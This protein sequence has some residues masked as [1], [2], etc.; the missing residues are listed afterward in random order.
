MASPQLESG[1]ARISH[2]LLQ[3]I[4][5]ARLK[6]APRAILDC[7]IAHTYGW[8]RKEAA[9]S[10]DAFVAWTGYSQ[11]TCRD[12]INSLARCRMITW[13]NHQKPRIFGV[14]KDYEKWK[15]PEH[16]ANK[17]AGTSGKLGC[18]VLQRKKKEEISREGEKRETWLT[19][20]DKLW[21][22][23]FGAHLPFGQAANYLD[24]LVKEH[25][26]AKTVAHFREWL[27]LQ[28]PQYVSLARFA[29]TFGSWD[30]EKVKQRQREKNK[31]DPLA[32]LVKAN[33][34][35]SKAI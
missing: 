35:A 34:E 21:Q 20:F 14:Q 7:I 33:Q 6:P 23:Q 1:Y 16:A 9:I 2:E 27:P 25:S 31:S 19:P 13:R 24:P 18:R 22:D 17:V 8:K 15:L 10:L 32:E 12:A 4:A 11:R 3:A 26:L 5:R 30:P 29:A 28:D